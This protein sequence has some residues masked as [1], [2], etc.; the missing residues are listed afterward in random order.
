[1][2]TAIVDVD[3]VVDVA[4]VD[5]ATYELVG[6]ADADDDGDVLELEALPGQTPPLSKNVYGLDESAVSLFSTE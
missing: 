5:G 4:K 2:I 3:V 6:V 1:M